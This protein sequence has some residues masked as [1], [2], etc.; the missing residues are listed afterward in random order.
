MT[1]T[2]KQKLAK[3]IADITVAEAIIGPNRL[4]PVERGELAILLNAARSVILQSEAEAIRDDI[5]QHPVIVCLCGSTKFKNAFIEA[6]RRE[7]LAG[8]I[9]LSV[10]CYMHADNIPITQEQKIALDELHKRKIDL[11]DE[12]LVLDVGGYIG[13]STAD[14]IEYAQKHNKSIRYLSSAP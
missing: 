3:V 4:I 5:A 12:V 7:T 1:P 10:G 8:K 9:V 13:A 14:E 6:T 11:C 2:E